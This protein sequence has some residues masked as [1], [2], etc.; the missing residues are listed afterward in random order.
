MNFIGFI[1]RTVVMMLLVL[2]RRFDTVIKFFLLLYIKI[3]LF[4]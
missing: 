4:Y 3:S 1:V 2:W